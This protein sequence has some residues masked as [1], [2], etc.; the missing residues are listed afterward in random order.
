MGLTAV[1][2]SHDLALVRYLCERTLVMYLGR[3][4]EDGPTEEIVRRP[5]HPYTRAPGRRR[6]GPRCRPVARAL[7]DQGQRARRARAAQRLPLPR[8]LPLR[9][10]PLV[11]TLRDGHDAACR[12]RIA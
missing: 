11:P 1:Y 4:V 12:A 5:R 7:A 8:P 10:A 6:S 3:I 2:I 9:D